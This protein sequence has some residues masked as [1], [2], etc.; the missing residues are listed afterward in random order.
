MQFTHR[1]W[2]QRVSTWSVLVTQ[3]WQSG[4]SWE[5]N[6]SFPGMVNYGCFLVE[7]NSS[8]VFPKLCLHVEKVLVYLSGKRIL[9]FCW[10]KCLESPCW[11]IPIVHL[12]IY[13]LIQPLEKAQELKRC[14]KCTSTH[15]IWH[16]IHDFSPWTYARIF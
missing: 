16:A 10:V 5:Y 1:E 6:G 13:S 2:V 8:A 9:I 14:N 4:C 3:C 12:V 7:G 15:I 11:R